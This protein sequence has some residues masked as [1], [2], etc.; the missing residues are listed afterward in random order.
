MQETQDYALRVEYKGSDEIGLLT[1][2]VNVLLAYIEKEDIMEEEI[3]KYLTIKAELDSLTEVYNRATIDDKLKN[4]L[5]SADKKGVCPAIAIVDI[6]DFR[7]FNTNYG[8]P[9]GDRVLKYVAAMLRQVTH[10]IVGR[11]GGDEFIVGIEDAG[12]KG[13][14]ERS[15]GEFLDRMQKGFYDEAAGKNISVTCSI[16]IAI[17]NQN[18]WRYEDMVNI[19][20]AVLYQVKETGKKAFQ[21]KEI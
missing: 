13:E 16:G 7:D 12:D 19:A 17:A 14:I 11:I 9:G 5:K 2:E 15:V 21:I 6:D 3:K 20:D 8:H 1:D 18:V 10:G 4:M